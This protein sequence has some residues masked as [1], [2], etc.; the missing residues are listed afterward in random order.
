[1]PKRVQRFDEFRQKMV[2]RA[3]HLDR[4]TGTQLLHQVFGGSQLMIG[5]DA[6]RH[7]GCKITAGEAASM[8]AHQLFRNECI[9]H[10]I[11]DARFAVDHAAHVHH[12]SKTGNLR[13][14]QHFIDHIGI[15]I[16]AGNLVA[17]GGRNAGRCHDDGP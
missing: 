7:E 9:L 12:F 17:G 11:A 3:T 8:A 1:M 16:R 13:P 2:M 6:S 4:Q 10:D 5:R 15:E 14:Q